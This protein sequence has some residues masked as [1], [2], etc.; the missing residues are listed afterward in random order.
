MNHPN[1][2]TL[3]YADQQA[4]IC[5]PLN[6]FQALFGQ[7]PWLLRPPYGSYNSATTQA[8][9][10][11]GLSAMVLW[12]ATMN[13]GVLTTQGGGLRPG[14]IILMH[15]RTDLRLNLEVALNAATAA[16]LHPA[17]LESYLP[18]PGSPGSPPSAQ[19]GS[20]P[21][22]Y[23]SAAAQLYFR[24]SR[25]SGFADSTFLAGA[26]GDI[27]LWCDWNNDGA[28]SWGVYRWTSGRFYLSNENFTGAADF[29]RVPLRQRG[30]SRRWW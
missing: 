21:G 9:A 7:R 18:S 11:C 2:T 24:N 10:A 30:R 5:G 19:A 8:A 15:F 23:R 25:A 13:D 29:H 6:D 28:A 26:P 3:S 20:K 4:E 1:L 16:G 12:R 27:A 14:D 17:P 22:V